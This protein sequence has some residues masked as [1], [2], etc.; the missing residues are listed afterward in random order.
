MRPLGAQH[1]QDTVQPTP[2]VRGPQGRLGHLA[3]VLALNWPRLQA[4]LWVFLLC[5]SLWPP[6]KIQ[7]MGEG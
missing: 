1:R 3:P 4:G 6:S 2:H 7:D 5:P